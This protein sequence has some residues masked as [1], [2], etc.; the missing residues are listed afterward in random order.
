MNW[1][2]II[3]D[4]MLGVDKHKEKYKAKDPKDLKKVE[5]PKDGSKI[6]EERHL[7]EKEISKSKEI[8]NQKAN[9]LERIVNHEEVRWKAI[10]EQENQV[11][12]ELDRVNAAYKQHGVLPGKGNDEQ[13]HQYMSNNDQHNESNGNYNAHQNN[14]Y[15][16]H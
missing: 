12:K 16:N 2:D 10:E 15:H 7:L 8:E 14:V 13:Q 11:K 6:K 4:I 5:V 3:K 9:V 1:L